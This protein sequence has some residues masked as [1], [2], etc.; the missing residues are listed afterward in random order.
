MY[1]DLFRKFGLV[2]LHPL[3]LYMYALIWL[4]DLKYMYVFFCCLRGSYE[5]LSLNVV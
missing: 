1:S 4:V 5:L 3:K 2:S